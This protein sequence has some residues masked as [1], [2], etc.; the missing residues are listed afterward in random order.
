MINKY[1]NANK[2]LKEF[3]AKK[4]KSGTAKNGAAYTVFTISDKIN[5]PDGSS[6]YDYY[7]VFSWQEDL[8]LSDG[9]KVVFEEITAIEIK[10]DVYNGKTSI[11]KTI[12]AD[13]KITQTNNPNKVEVV[14]ESKDGDPFDSLGD[15]LPF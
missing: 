1:K 9:D 8:R 14:G 12:F 13:V 6:T 3:T 4:V 2:D 7:S 15:N 11:K 5:K 10:E